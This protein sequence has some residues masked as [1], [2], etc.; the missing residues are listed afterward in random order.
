M[1]T[2]TSRAAVEFVVDYSRLPVGDFDD[3]ERGRLARLLE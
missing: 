2:H 3:R 1:A